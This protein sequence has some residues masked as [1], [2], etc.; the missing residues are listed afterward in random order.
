MRP[1]I[2]ASLVLSLVAA[3]CNVYEGSPSDQPR[4]IQDRQKQALKDPFRYSPDLGD[5]DISGGGIRDFDKSAF[6]RDVDSVFSP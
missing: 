5:N 3:G 4:R 2:L 6:K 1:I